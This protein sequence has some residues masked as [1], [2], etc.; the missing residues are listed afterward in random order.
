VAFSV[1]V[2]IC[3]N[4]SPVTPVVVYSAQIAPLYDVPTVLEYAV[5]HEAA[6]EVNMAGAVNDKAM[7]WP[8]E[9]APVE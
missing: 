9:M 6:P 4:C 3:V 5:P 2:A 1:A 8:E 7:V